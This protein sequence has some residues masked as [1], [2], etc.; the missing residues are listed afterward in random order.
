MEVLSKALAGGSQPARPCPGTHRGCGCSKGQAE[1]HEQWDELFTCLHVGHGQSAV[2]A[3]EAHLSRLE[4]VGQ[5]QEVEGHD[6]GCHYGQL[7]EECWPESHHACSLSESSAHKFSPITD[8]STH[9]CCS[10]TDQL[11][12]QP[13]HPPPICASNRAIPAPKINSS[14]H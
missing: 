5:L 8:P 3:L 10:S 1:E 11:I 2:I 9:L 7:Q 12:H 4:E 6:G 14:I 13:S